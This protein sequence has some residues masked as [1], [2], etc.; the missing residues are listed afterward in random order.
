MTPGIDTSRFKIV[1]SD[2]KNDLREKL[3][4]PLN[5]KIFL[6]VGRLVKAKGIDYLIGAMEQLGDDCMAVL[7]GEGEQRQSLLKAIKAQSLE[8]ESYLRGSNITGRR[9]LPSMRCFCHELN[10]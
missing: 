6:F 7:V 2:E 10:L 8:R 3:G 4:L 1:S 9:I 5:K